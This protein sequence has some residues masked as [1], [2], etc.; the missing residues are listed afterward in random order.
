MKIPFASLSSWKFAAKLM[1]YRQKRNVLNVILGHAK[2]EPGNLEIPDM[3]LRTI[4]E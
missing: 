4:P 1:R 3:V 2:R